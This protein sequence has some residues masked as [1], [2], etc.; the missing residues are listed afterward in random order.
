M[1]RHAYKK[2]K[3]TNDACNANGCHMHTVV[4]SLGVPPCDRCG[5]SPEIPQHWFPAKIRKP[6]PARRAEIAELTGTLEA[7]W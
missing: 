6:G 7:H 5:G 4:G 1:D 3:I 2:R